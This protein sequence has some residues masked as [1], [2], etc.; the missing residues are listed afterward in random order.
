VAQNRGLF[1]YFLISQSKQSSI[2][3]IPQSGHPGLVHPQTEYIILLGSMLWSLFSAILTNF[4]RK[5]WRF[6]YNLVLRLFS[7]ASIATF[8]VRIGLFFSISSSDYFSKIIT[9]TPDQSY[10]RSFSSILPQLKW[11]PNSKFRFVGQYYVCMFGNGNA[12]MKHA[13]M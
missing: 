3:R 7:S 6:S 2:G 5:N 10:I 12:R 11:L 4:L 8:L 9:L 1:L 13:F